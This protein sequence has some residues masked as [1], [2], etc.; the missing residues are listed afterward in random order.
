M[1]NHDVLY[2]VLAGSALLVRGPIPVALNF[3]EGAGSATGPG[4]SHLAPTWLYQAL[5][6]YPSPRTRMRARQFFADLPLFL[7]SGRFR[8]T[9]VTG[10]GARFWFCRQS[11]RR[12]YFLEQ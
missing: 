11:L 9:L 12:E 8:K 10:F 6:N 5:G 4:L 7:R 2:C 1:R 3:L